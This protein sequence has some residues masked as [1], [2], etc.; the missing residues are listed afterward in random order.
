LIELARRPVQP[1]WSAE[2]RERFWQEVLERAERDRQ[3]RR[4][5]RAFAAGAGTVLLVGLLLRLIGAVASPLVCPSPEL[6][7]KTP[8]G[9]LAAE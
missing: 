3:R 1:E 9:Q 2:R 6:A 4:V 8:V 7:G 5:R